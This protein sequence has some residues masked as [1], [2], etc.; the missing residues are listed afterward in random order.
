[1][2]VVLVCVCLQYLVFYCINDAAVIFTA[3]LVL[4]FYVSSTLNAEYLSQSDA[5]SGRR[6]ARV[7]HVQGMLT[8]S[9]PCTCPISLC[10]PMP[11]QHFTCLAVW[12]FV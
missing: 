10:C 6:K 5:V 9:M 8:L 1:M 2:S 4:S 11:V 3:F 12:D 7:L